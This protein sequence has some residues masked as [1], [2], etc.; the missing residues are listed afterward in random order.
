LLTS[1]YNADGLLQ[2]RESTVNGASPLRVD[3]A[4]DGDGRVTGMARYADLAGTQAV[5]TTTQQYDDASLLTSIIH[6]G[7]GGAGVAAYSYSYDAGNRLT[8]ETD[9]GTTTT[10]GYDASNE[11]TTVNGQVLYTYDLAGNRTGTSYDTGAANELLD[12]GTWQY[13][14]DVE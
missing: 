12:D 10:Y 11:L 13:L 6:A 9:D 4:Y 7:V 3:F 8:S 5:V 2:T 1:V 14:Y